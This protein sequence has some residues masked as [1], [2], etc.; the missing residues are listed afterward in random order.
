MRLEALLPQGPKFE[1]FDIELELELGLG[2][3][4]EL[5]TETETE[6]AQWRSSPLASPQ[7]GAAKR[8]TNRLSAEGPVSCRPAGELARRPNREHQMQIWRPPQIEFARLCFRVLA[9][10][11]RRE[12]RVGRLQS[13]D[14]HL[15]QLSCL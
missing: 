3:E 15:Q 5:E 12:L 10:D 6:G 8:H 4:L 14:L 7:S 9:S 13:R 11:S 1:Y 2:L